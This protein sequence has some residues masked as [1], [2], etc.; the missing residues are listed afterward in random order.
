MKKLAADRER[1]TVCSPIEG[2]VYDGKC[3]HGKFGDS[4]SLG[5][6]LRPA[7]MAQMNQ[8]LMPALNG[9]SQ[10]TCPRRSATRAS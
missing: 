3:T 8:V 6:A 7:G 2:V 4:Q 1:L 5:D 10:D 9:D